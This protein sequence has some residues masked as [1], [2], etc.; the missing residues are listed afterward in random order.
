MKRHQREAFKQ[1]EREAVEVV[2]RQK[3][4]AREKQL[5]EHNIGDPDEFDNIEARDYKDDNS[6]SSVD[7]EESR[8]TPRFILLEGI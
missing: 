3:Q 6:E 4:P 8:R 5:E 7:D 2:E 1:L